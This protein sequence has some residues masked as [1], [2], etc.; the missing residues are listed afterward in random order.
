MISRVGR[1]LFESC[2]DQFVQSGQP[3]RLRKIEI[4]LVVDTSNR[5]SII[6]DVCR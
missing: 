4:R 5:N 1:D 6:P 2:I 3:Q